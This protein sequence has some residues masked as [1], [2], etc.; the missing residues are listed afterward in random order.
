[1][2]PGFVFKCQEHDQIVKRTTDGRNSRGQRDGEKGGNVPYS[3]RRKGGA[4]VVVPSEAAV[5]R[6]VFTL[7]WDRGGAP[8]RSVALGAVRHPSYARAVY[9]SSTRR[10]RSVFQRLARP[11][12]SPSSTGIVP[13]CWYS[14]SQWPS[15]SRFASTNPIASATRSSGLA[16]ALRR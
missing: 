13:G 4:I 14:S 9:Q 8:P 15:P 6:R 5:V 11:T 2:T 16:P 1:M 7:R 3:Y 10:A 12:P